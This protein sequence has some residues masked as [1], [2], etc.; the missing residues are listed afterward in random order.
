[1]GE[2]AEG[3]GDGRAGWEEGK[4]LRFVGRDDTVQVSPEFMRASP[5]SNC[6]VEGYHGSFSEVF[7]KLSA[8]TNPA[9]VACITWF[10]HNLGTLLELGVDLSRVDSAH[11][12]KA[13]G[14][15]S[16]W[17]E[18]NLV[19]QKRVHKTAITTTHRGQLRKELAATIKAKC[20]A[21]G[22]PYTN[23]NDS[24]FALAEA[25]YVPP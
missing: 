4:E 13:E 2:S 16:R 25:L 24:I 20:A 11:W 15:A 6:F 23:K 22:V 12:Q 17:L 21:A 7:D 10:K 9:R 14:L 5:A 3:V 19:V 18:S 8:M 1:M